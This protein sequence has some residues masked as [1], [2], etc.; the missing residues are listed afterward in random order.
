MNKNK[1]VIRNTLQDLRT[2]LFQEE[3]DDRISPSHLSQ[4]MKRTKG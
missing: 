1:V 2:D 4:I 3:G